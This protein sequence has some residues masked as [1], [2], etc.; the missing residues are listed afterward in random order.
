MVEFGVKFYVSNPSRLVHDYTRYLT[1]AQLKEVGPP[2][3]VELTQKQDLATGRFTCALPEGLKLCAYT[4]Q[5]ELGCA[6]R[7]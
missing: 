3:S 7:A 1:Y 6:G 4:V 2:L 5:A